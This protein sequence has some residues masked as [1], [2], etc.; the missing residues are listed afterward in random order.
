LTGVLPT[1]SILFRPQSIAH[2]LNDINVASHSDSKRHW[3]CLQLRFEASKDVRLEM[4]SRRAA[5][6]GN[7]SL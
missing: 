4:L 3:V 5:L 6:R 7:T 1:L 2:P